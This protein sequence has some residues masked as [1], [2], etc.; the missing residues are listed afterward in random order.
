VRVWTRVGLQSF[1]GPAGQIAVM[2]R[3]LVDEK[4]WV[5]ESRFLHALN[6]CMLAGARGA[7]ALD[8]HRL[9]PARV[10]R[11]QLIADKYDGSSRRRPGRRTTPH[12]LRQLVARFARENPTW[13]YTRLRGALQNLGHHLGRNTIKR[14]LAEQGL[15]PAPERGK[16]D[17]AREVHL[18]AHFSEIASG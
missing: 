4:R 1:G 16:V 10:P 5:S 2:H 17:A 3:I 8:L 7:A 9:A 12:E 11:R 6:Y 15:E 18:E 13:G 14:I